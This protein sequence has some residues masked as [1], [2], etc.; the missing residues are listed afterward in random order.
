MGAAG[1]TVF[2]DVVGG[3]NAE[4]IG[5][6]QCGPTDQ[7]GYTPAVGAE[8]GSGGHPAS[9]ASSACGYTDATGTGSP[10]GTDEIVAWV[11]I[12]DPP[13]GQVDNPNT[14]D[15]GEAQMTLSV[16]WGT[17][18]I[19]GPGTTIACTPDGGVA[20]PGSLVD[21]ICSLR[22]ASGEPIPGVV[23]SLIE[24][25]PG[26]FSGGS[27]SATCT[28]GSNGSC[29]VQ[30]VSGVNEWGTTT[31]IGSITH[32]A[33]AS[34]GSDCADEASIVWTDQHG[35]RWDTDVG[36]RYSRT[37]HRF[38]G[39]VTSETQRCSAGRSVWIK[40]ARPGLDR[41][42]AEVIT[43]ETGTFASR[44]FGDPRGR[45]YAAVPEMEI[46]DSGDICLRAR[47]NVVR[48]R[49]R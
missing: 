34:P 28:T 7:A 27:S 21:V 41:R 2:F 14:A 47:S 31:I 49:R 29:T 38:S 24:E 5:P 1:R 8:D 44:R 13:P 3:P 4:E 12:E 36:L 16:R 42:V 39:K 45:F 26:T 43:S 48:V 17:S 46:S 30:M 33:C 32:D 15:P 35:V 6:T 25:G 23:V 18:P 40:K 20:P 37:G 10:E 11:N 22:T 9:S 19:V